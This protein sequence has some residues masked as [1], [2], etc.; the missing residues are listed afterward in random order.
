MNLANQRGDAI[1][2]VNEPR[3]SKD[4][5]LWWVTGGYASKI[6]EVTSA[7]TGG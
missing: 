3:V 2:L 4:I 7:E 5:L 1:D 6:Y